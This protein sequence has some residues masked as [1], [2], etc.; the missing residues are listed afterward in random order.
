MAERWVTATETRR[1]HGFKMEFKA[2]QGKT[3]ANGNRIRSV[4]YTDYNFQAA[5]LVEAWR[6]DR[7]GRRINGETLWIELPSINGFVPRIDDMTLMIAGNNA[8]F[9]IEA[10]G[11]TI[12]NE[13]DAFEFEHVEQGW[14]ASFPGVPGGEPEGA[15]TYIPSGSGGGDVGGATK[16]EV[17]AIVD[18]AVHSI[19]G[20]DNLTLRLVIDNMT[21]K[22]ELAIANKKVLTEANAKDYFYQFFKDRLYEVFAQNVPGFWDWLNLFVKAP[23]PR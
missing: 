11:E 20:Q 4:V 15:E 1:A 12:N 14:Y 22:A 2:A 3:D 9:I 10:H 21:S 19:K 6:E 16:E 8:H 7:Q 13:R 23:I 17:Q 5:P 18:A